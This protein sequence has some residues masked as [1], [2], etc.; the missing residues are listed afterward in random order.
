MTPRTASS[1]TPQRATRWHLS[2]LTGALATAALLLAPGLAPAALPPDVQNIKDAEALLQW[3][4]ERPWVAA[5]LTRLD[6]REA[7]VHWGASCT[8][9][10]ERQR[11]Q[12]RLPPMPGPAA[13]LVFKAAN[14]PLDR[15]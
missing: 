12:D 8:A 4:R 15:P 1:P 2:P 6:V 10:F 3:V 11:P 14:C 7:R 9:T 13:P 5:Q